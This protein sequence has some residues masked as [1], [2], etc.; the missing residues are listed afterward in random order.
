MTV[1]AKRIRTLTLRGRKWKVRWPVKLVND[2]GKPLLGQCHHCCRTLFIA[3]DQ[4]NDEL[5][6]TLIHE[7]LH[8]C[9]PRVREKR[10]ASAAGEI[11]KALERLGLLRIPKGKT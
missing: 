1:T 4:P 5:A 11:F 8:G 2:S 3:A 6:D 10:I 7:M 9:F